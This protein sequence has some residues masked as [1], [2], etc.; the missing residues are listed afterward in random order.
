MVP[1]SIKDPKLKK[2]GSVTITEVKCAPDLRNATVRFTLYTSETEET[3]RLRSAKDAE[4][5]LNKAAGFLRREL[6]ERL[7][8]KY[9]PILHFSFD[10]GM[11]HAVKI[12]NLLKS[13]TATNDDSEES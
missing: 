7:G 5:L 3:K 6:S 10:R 12:N 2:C 11:D 8:I 9:T 4:T 13:A 1:D